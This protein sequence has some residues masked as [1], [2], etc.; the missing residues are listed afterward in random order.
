ML[1]IHNLDGDTEY[2]YIRIIVW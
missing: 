2:L 1:F